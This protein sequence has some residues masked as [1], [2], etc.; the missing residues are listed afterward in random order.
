MKNFF[1]K[2]NNKRWIFS[3]SIAFVSYLLTV[4]TVYL[5]AHGGGKSIAY[6]FNR[7][8]SEDQS[9]FSFFDKWDLFSTLNAVD[10]S[11]FG[12]LLVS[13]I[14]VAIPYLVI[15]KYFFDYRNE[16]N[17]GWKRVFLTLQVVIPL[18]FCILSY[19]G[20]NSFSLMLNGLILTFGISELGIL[21][22]IKAFSWF[23]DGFSS[24]EVRALKEKNVEHSR[25]L[26]AEEERV[27]IEKKNNES[28]EANRW[29]E[30]VDR[31]PNKIQ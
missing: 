5:D 28:I 4:R 11:Y 30:E 10:F 9:K 21:A 22:I 27:Q 6:N 25:A 13:L 26:E 15:S 16:P 2:T 1:M 18:F 31:I 20:M 24:K 3:I 19:D 12:N 23:K 17:E 29:K 7:A 8:F 14:S